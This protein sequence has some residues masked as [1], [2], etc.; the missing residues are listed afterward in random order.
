MRRNDENK[1]QEIRVKIRVKI[2]LFFVN[3]LLE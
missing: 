1:T 3:E 2:I